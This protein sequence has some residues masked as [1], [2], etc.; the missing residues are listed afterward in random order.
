MR[1]SDETQSAGALRGEPPEAIDRRRALA[2]AI[3]LATTVG[4]LGLAAVLRYEAPESV[5]LPGWE[6]PLPE[7]CLMRR[8]L[9]MPCPGCG[10]TRS[11]ILAADGRL[12]AAAAMHPVGLVL[13]A[14]F[15][16]QVPLRCHQLLRFVRGRSVYATLQYDLVLLIG[17][18]LSLWIWWGV[19]LALP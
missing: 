15:A 1:F 19:K 4:V 13:F 3:W 14:L 5:R 17:L 6:R 16:S 11:F 2:A 10:L 8:M 12:A 7:I 18:A 9:A